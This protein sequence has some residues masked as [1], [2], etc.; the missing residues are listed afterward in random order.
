MKIRRVA[1]VGD[2]SQRIQEDYLRILRYF[3]FRGR[4]SLQPNNHEKETEQALRDNMEGLK[5]IS[6]ERIW[7]ELKQILSHRRHA[8]PILETMLDLG[9]APYIGIKQDFNLDEFKTVWE[10]AQSND[11]QLQPISLLASL[12]DSEEDV[13]TIFVF[14]I[15]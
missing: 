3:R 6:G 11:I 10:K 9:I 12:I 13:I 1:F 8:G 15:D 2:P 7:V 14:I 4:I 5:G